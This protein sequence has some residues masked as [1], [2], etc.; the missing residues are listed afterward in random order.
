VRVRFTELVDVNNKD[1]IDHEESADD[2]AGTGL[3]EPDFDQP[4]R[5]MQAQWHP[6]LNAWIADMS[7]SNGTFLVFGALQNM[8]RHRAFETVSDQVDFA[9]AVAPEMATVD[10]PQPPQNVDQMAGWDFGLSMWNQMV[11][12]PGSTQQY[13]FFYAVSTSLEDAVSVARR[14]L[15]PRAPELWFARTNAVYRTWLQEGP[16]VDAPDPG[17]RT[18]YNRALITIKQSQQPQF[19]SFVAATNP[20]Y[21]HKVWARDSSVT[22]LGL[23]AAGHLNEAIKY[24]RWMASVQEDGSREN[25]PRGTWFVT[26]SYW[27]RK[28]PIPFV[29]PELDSLGLFM[30]GVYH[31]WRLLNEQ[32]PAA[33]REFLTGRFAR[34]DQGPT[35]VYDAVT[36]AADF[37]VNNINENNFGPADHSIWEEDFEWAT[38]TQAAYASGLNAAR[39]LAE[40]MGQTNRASAWLA[41]AR[42]IRDAISRPASSTPCPGLWNDTESRWNRGTRLDCT[43]DSRL[44]ASTDL[45][46]VFGL[47]DASDPRVSSHRAAVLARLTPGYDDL[48]IARYEGDQFYFQSPFSPG[49]PLEATAELPS[50]P[51]MDMYV[52]MLEHWS[53]LDDMALERLKWYVKVTNVGDMPPGEAVDWPTDRPLPS[54][55]SEPVTGSW[56]VLGLLN[57]FNLFD[58][59]LPSLDTVTTSAPT[60]SPIHAAATAS[61]RQ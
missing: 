36:R 60:P 10:Q 61:A 50:W 23:A 48:G 55:S 37:V 47:I 43:T 38:F 49:G 6:E 40:N 52:G 21:G 9:T 14:A 42:R 20:A 17:L 31:T 5:N 7:A 3:S 30:T 26:Y 32:D 22:A 27:L 44:D 18:A 51:Q 25:F 13:Y 46:W 54:T 16:Q 1:E 59:R 24:Y 19:G 11:L 33:A 35:S 45:V 39:L 41:G 57:F 2:L 4:I 58:P 34:I 29:D 8:D 28:N 12:G 15:Q 53:A 56:Y